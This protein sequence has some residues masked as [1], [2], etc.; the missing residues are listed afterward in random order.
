MR[1]VIKDMITCQ[2]DTC[3]TKGH[4]TIPT[5]VN[6]LDYGSCMLK[7]HMVMFEIANNIAKQTEGFK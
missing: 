7:Q 6:V 3:C 1:P 2:T 4:N 5:E